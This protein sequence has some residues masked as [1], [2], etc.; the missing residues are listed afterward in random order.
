M[1][2]KRILHKARVHGL[3][4]FVALMG[5]CRITHGD[6]EWSYSGVVTNVPDS[7]Y[8]I[9]DERHTGLLALG[10]GTPVPLDGI[11][12]P[13]KGSPE[14]KVFLDILKKTLLGKQVNVKEITDGGTSRGVSVYY[15]IEGKRRFA[16]ED[17]VNLMLVREGFARYSGERGSGDRNLGGMAEAQRLAQEEKK[18]IWAHYKP[19]TNTVQEATPEPIQPPVTIEQTQS[20]NV[21][22]PDPQPPPEPQTTP[23]KLPL[24]IG[25]IA[26]AGA[27][28]AWRY[29]RK[30]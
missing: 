29:F 6:V 17:N 26:T 10:R 5:I 20:V 25:L 14:E 22:A 1:K 23:W 2:V 4:L 13:E 19:E 7:T 15:A 30:K 16:P 24:L 27:I 21:P 9:I 18:G 3:I 12:V 28:T 8:V 11:A